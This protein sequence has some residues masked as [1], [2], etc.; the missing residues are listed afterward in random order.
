MF[1]MVE[2]IVFYSTHKPKSSVWNAIKVT[3]E[4]NIKNYTSVLN[5]RSHIKQKYL[6]FS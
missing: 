5:I 6:A 1:S 2:I 3:F 4:H